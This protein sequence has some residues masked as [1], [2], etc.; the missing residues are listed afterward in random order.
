MIADPRQMLSG[1]RR[2]AL[3]EKAR[4]L[5]SYQV[6]NL[7]FYINTTF[8]GPPRS[9]RCFLHERIQQYSLTRGFVFDIEI[10]R[11]QRTLLGSL[12]LPR[13]DAHSNARYSCNFNSIFATRLARGSIG[14]C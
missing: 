10:L 12:S 2:R 6:R 14:D 8:F 13:L 1:C 11:R 5:F 3:A 9:L 7:L 4:V